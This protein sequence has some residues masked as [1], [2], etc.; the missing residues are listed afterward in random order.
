[1]AGLVVLGVIT[2]PHGVRG[3]VRVH[4][5]NPGSSLLLEL[6]RVVLV[7]K[8]GARRELAIRA[9]K[10]SGDA[11][12]LW[13]EGCAR[14]ED[15]EALRGAELAVEREALPSPAEG[16]HY[17]VDL[18]GMK[19]IEATAELG[20]V[21][22]IAS[23]PSVDVLRVRTGRGI[24]EIPILDPYV[25]SIDRHARTIEVAFSEDFEPE[26]GS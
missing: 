19:V 3:E 14:H 13:L 25:I 24:L 6:E 15:A 20:E 4:R 11:D 9:A 22:G 16:E 18:V 21:I 8:H 23:H 26:I 5:F 10:R 2:R 1:M 12:V 7:P 17:H